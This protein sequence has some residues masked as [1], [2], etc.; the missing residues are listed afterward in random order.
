[1]ASYDPA[2]DP[3]EDDDESQHSISISDNSHN[4]S[5][6]TKL[7]TSN[8]PHDIQHLLQLKTASFNQPVATARY[9][10]IEQQN[11]H[12][13]THIPQESTSDHFR[14]D[15]KKLVAFSLT[16]VSSSMSI[17][18]FVTDC[19]L[20]YK[21]SQNNVLLLTIILFISIIFIWN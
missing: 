16:V 2:H 17:L 15:I 7:D 11:D 3:N 10:V 19:I 1:M 9:A 18:D 14:F 8:L 20:L 21:A 13:I 5:N 12:E 6:I 4:T